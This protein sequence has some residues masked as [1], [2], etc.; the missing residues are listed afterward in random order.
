MQLGYKLVYQLEQGNMQ[1]SE[2][3][4]LKQADRFGYTD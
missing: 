2:T 3:V 1:E 4:R